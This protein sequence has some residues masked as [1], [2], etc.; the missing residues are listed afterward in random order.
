VDFAE[1]DEQHAIRDVVRRFAEKEIAPAYPEW[2]LEESFPKSLN[3]RL[4]ELGL[5]GGAM[6][7]RYGGS[8][9]DFVTLAIVM[10]ELG[11]FCPMAAT[12]CG[13]P[14]CSLGRG[15]LVYG[16]EEQRQRYLRPTLEGRLVGATAVTEPHSGTDVLRRME[17]TARR[18]GSAYVLNGSKAWVSNIE[19]ADWFLTFATVDRSR[20]YKGVCAFVVE[21]GFGGVTTQ[22]YRNKVSSRTH[23]NGEFALSDVRVPAEN[24]IGEEGAGYKVLAAGTEIGRLACAA[25]AV[26]QLRACLDLSVR[27]ARVRTTFGQPI[28]QYQLVQQKIAAMS[29][30]L[31]AARLLTYRLAW[32]QDSGQQRLQKQAAAAKVFATDALMQAATDAMQIHGAYGCSGDVEIGRIWRDAKA[33]QIYDGTNEILTVQIA[34]HELGYRT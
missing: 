25:R 10:E 26:G 32:L 34:E 30:N 11:Y 33:T 6:P 17:T 28:G 24:L 12:V 16:S 1:T 22:K 5:L 3:S 20:G 8:D 9:L 29:V 2:D 13:Q 23:V 18:D 7:A 4:A 19:N 15:L 14:S 31:E 21:R 27:Y